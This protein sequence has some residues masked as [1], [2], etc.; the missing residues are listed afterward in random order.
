[1]R[2]CEREK[3]TQRER[4]RAREEETRWRERD[5]RAFL[6][7][8][9]PRGGALL[10]HRLARGARGRAVVARGLIVFVGF[11]G[12]AIHAGGAGRRH[13]DGAALARV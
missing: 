6:A 9:I 4:K 2:A 10:E 3:K 5:R 12:A 13:G 7:H 8:A 11:E 1:M